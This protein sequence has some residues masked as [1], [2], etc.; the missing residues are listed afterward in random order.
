MVLLKDVSTK[1]P[2][3][4][5]KEQA[6]EETG[7]IK[8]KLDDLQN[9]LFAEGR[10]AVLVVI[11]GMDGSGKDGAIKNVFGGLNPQGIQVKSFKAPT[12]EEL[13]HDFLWR[14][15]QHAPAKGMIQVFNRSHYEDVLVTRVHGWCD[16]ETAQKR[17]K[18]IN[19][20]EKLLQEHNQTTLLKFYLHVS[21]EE[22]QERLKERTENPEKM[23]K[24]N[25]K[26][27][28]EAKLWDKYMQMYEDVFAHCNDPEWTI[29]PADQNWYKEYLIAKTLLTALEELKMSYP[30]LRKE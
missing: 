29:V 21:P 27:F 13:N 9:L 17:F 12:T 18:A 25:A 28:D 8:K 11:Q 7:K 24:Y 20:F 14:I 4:F 26:D 2:K 5:D 10:H 15:H 6:K 16:D 3:E 30:L 22:Q 23:W 1:S 19:H